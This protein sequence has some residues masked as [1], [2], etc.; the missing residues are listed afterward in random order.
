M[1]GPSITARIRE[2]RPTTRATMPTLDEIKDALGIP[3]SDTSQDQAITD[4]VAATLAIIEAYLGRGIAWGPMVQTFE[5]VDTRNPKLLLY[6]FPV[7]TVRTVM[8][9]DSP[10]DGWRVLKA[11]GVIEWRDGCGCVWPS[12]VCGREPVVVVDYDGGYADDAWP[13]DLMDAIMRAFYA[14]WHATGDTGNTADMSTGGPITSLSV[15]GS[16]IAFGEPGVNAAEFGGKPW[17]PELSGV[18]SILE[19]YRQ[20]LVTGV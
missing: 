4:A 6:R 10:L 8:V 12:N 19:P 11:Q 18:I 5:P 1:T 14:R 2:Q 3:A 16:S 17:P 9:D 7:T 13:A 20:R 15:D